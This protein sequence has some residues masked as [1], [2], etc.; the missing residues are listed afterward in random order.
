LYNEDIND[1]RADTNP[2]QPTPPPIS[3]KEIGQDNDQ[4]V[5]GKGYQYQFGGYDRH[6]E[7]CENDGSKKKINPNDGLIPAVKY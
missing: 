2:G 1:S 3:Q 5:T 4:E 6:N 7:K